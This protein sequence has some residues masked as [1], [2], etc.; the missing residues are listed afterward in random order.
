MHLRTGKLIVAL[1][2]NAVSMEASKVCCR[3]LQQDNWSIEMIG[4]CICWYISCLQWVC[5]MSLKLFLSK[6][7][8]VLRMVA[9][10]YKSTKKCNAK[11]SYVFSQLSVSSYVELAKKLDNIIHT[12]FA[13]HSFRFRVRLSMPNYI[14]ASQT[15]HTTNLVTTTSCKKM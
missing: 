2:R 10:V 14:T 7:L 6:R 5:Y 15:L 12:M 11:K 9:S 4:L 3:L 1:F 13:C 8:L